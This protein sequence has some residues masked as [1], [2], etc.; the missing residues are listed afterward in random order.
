MGE[1]VLDV[2]ICF[3]AAFIR[4]NR[5][6]RA[7]AGI[8]QQKLVKTRKIERTLKPPCVIVF[9]GDSNAGKTFTADFLAGPDAYAFMV[10]GGNTT[11]WDGYEGQD[12]IVI[13]EFGKG[14]SMSFTEFK[15]M[16]DNG[17]Q[18]QT[19]GGTT[20]LIPKRIWITSN[21]DPL[22]WYSNVTNRKPLYRRLTYVYVF[23]GD[24]DEGTV[25]VQIDCKPNSYNSETEMYEMWAPSTPHPDK[26]D[27]ELPLTAEA[28]N[29]GLSA[30]I[31]SPPVS[32]S[33]QLLS[34]MPDEEEAA[35][36]AFDEFWMAPRHAQEAEWKVDDP[37]QDDEW[38]DQ[39][40]EFWRNPFIEFEAE[41]SENENE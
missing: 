3:P 19:K 22:N 1:R 14:G 10:Q 25:T 20:W 30:E 2:A 11:W 37:G 6:I 15:I 7:L 34:P 9:H 21:D 33:L 13:Q 24:H 16:C 8:Y 18:V 31:L 27:F 39:Q 41:A 35:R 17:I 29:Q 40:A 36:I 4:Y 32:E 5:G 23:K 26:P 38:W 28:I 12:D